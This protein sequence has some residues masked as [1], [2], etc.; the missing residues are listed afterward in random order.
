MPSV[1]QEPIARRLLRIVII[2]GLTIISVP[3]AVAGTFAHA[4]MLHAGA[5]PLPYGL[6]LALG[7]LAAVL[8][9]AHRVART[10]L[11]R[12]PVA[13]AW[14]VPAWVLAQDRPAGDVVIANGWPGLVFLFG[15]VVLVG[16]VLGLPQRNP[17]HR[18]SQDS[19]A[20]TA[21]RYHS[22]G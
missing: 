20:V 2:T 4:A 10:R 16:V 3:V 5:V 15:S 17:A 13:V 8:V 6:V 1:G 14:V 12:I 19:E 7:A 21:V 18:T 22:G 9:L 11:G